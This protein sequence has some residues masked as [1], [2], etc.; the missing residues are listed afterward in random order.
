M[1]S[2]FLLLQTGLAA[3]LSTDWS[4]SRRHA[5][6]P[7]SRLLQRSTREVTKAA[8]DRLRSPKRQR[9]DA[10]PDET[11]LVKATAYRP[12]NMAPHGQAGCDLPWGWEGSTHL[13][14]LFDPTRAKT[15]IQLLS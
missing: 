4:P 3:T 6:A 9:L 10:A 13:F 2:Y 5:C 7:A 12:S 8:K 11:E 14:V 1:W 15:S